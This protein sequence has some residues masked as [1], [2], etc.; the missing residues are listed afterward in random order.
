MFGTFFHRVRAA[1]AGPWSIVAIVGVL[2]LPPLFVQRR[3]PVAAYC[4]EC[5]L[6]RETWSWQLW[7]APGVT[8]FSRSEETPTLVSN[9]VAG[10]RLVGPHTH[11]WLE[12]RIVRNPLNAYGPP[13]TLSPGFLN[14]PQVAGFLSNLGE[15]AEPDIA[16]NGL[17]LALRPEYSYLINHTLRFHKFPAR[18]F[19]DRT[20]FL[21]WW[22]QNGFSFYSHLRAETEPD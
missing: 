10:K 13:V 19:H 3:A 18:G 8:L 20:Q 17:Q 9:A 1:L 15:F 12:P 16:R 11:R 4:A 14:T 21:A 5:V 22:G 2:V 6:R 7:G